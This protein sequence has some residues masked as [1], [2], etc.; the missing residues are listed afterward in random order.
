MTEDADRQGRPTRLLL[1]EDEPIVASFL[2]RVLQREGY[3]VLHARN[4]EEGL[5]RLH[6]ESFNVVLSD[7]QM[8]G[9]S[10]LDVVRAVR[11]M[12]ADIPVLMVTGLGDE[13]LAATALKEGAADY[14]MKDASGRYVEVLPRAIESALENARARRA[15][16]TAEAEQGRLLQE[17]KMRVRELG[18]L[19]AAERLFAMESFKTDEV[20]RDVV[21]LVTNACPEEVTCSARLVLGKAVY[22]NE[23]FKEEGVRKVYEIIQRKG[24]GGQLE[25]FFRGPAPA[26][27]PEQEEL[28][29]ALAYRIGQYVERIQDEE[30]LRQIHDELRKLSRAVEQSGSA[31]VITDTRGVIEYVNP[32]FTEMTGYDRQEILG[33][34][35]SVLKSGEKSPRDYAELWE[36]ILSGRE[37]RGEFRN[38]RKDGTFY[39][40]ASTI[41]PITNSTGEITHYIAIKEDI[42]ARKEAE[43][44]RAGVLKIS[45]AIAG[46]Q[47]E[48]DICRAVVEGIRAHLGFDRCGLFLEEPDHKRF[49]GT[50]GTDLQGGTTDEHTSVHELS[51]TLNM[52]PLFQGALYQTGMPLGGPLAREGEE[53]LSST[54]VALRKGTWVFGVIS[55]DNRITR[56]PISEAQLNHAALLAEVLGNALQTARARKALDASIEE[57]QKANRELEAFNQAMVGREERIIALKEEVNA[58]LK[59]AGL[60][61][62]YPPVWEEE[63]LPSAPAVL[64]TTCREEKVYFGS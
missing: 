4:G 22:R 17:L 53:D 32:K 31:V 59:Q 3:E 48:D 47:T 13:K 49:R 5:A 57:V 42:T 50:Y 12:D 51:R 55:V 33:R 37:W 6:D 64:Q 45:V 11:A 16:Q 61:P 1:I 35:P 26:L 39:W 20:L 40:D 15:L 19:Y 30:H 56:H 7:Y 29:F 43:R 27:S 54:M 41:S 52:K 36:T 9:M 14:I 63:A 24:P 2:Q 62:R 23:E 58:V 46:C 10:G 44:L 18:C 8:P 60:A 34:D 25:L 21:E 28:L 38:R